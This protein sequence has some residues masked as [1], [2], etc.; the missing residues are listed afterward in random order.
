MTGFA[1]PEHW[2][3]RGGPN[4]HTF[5]DEWVRIAQGQ[6]QH[7]RKFYLYAVCPDLPLADYRTLIEMC[8]ELA[9]Q[10]KWSEIIFERIKHGKTVVVHIPIKPERRVKPSNVE[11]S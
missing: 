8:R 4:A 6:V 10:Y 3:F 7:D 1:D 2:T 5:G 9:H 11:L